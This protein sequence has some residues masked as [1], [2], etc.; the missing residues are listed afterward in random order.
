MF[1]ISH[2]PA[3]QDGDQMANSMVSPMLA[4]MGVPSHTPHSAPTDYQPHYNQHDLPP[5]TFNNLPH[6]SSSEHHSINSASTLE[7]SPKNSLNTIELDMEMP[8]QQ[9]SNIHGSVEGE[10]NSALF[11][12]HYKQIEESYR[13]T[14]QPISMQQSVRSI[15]MTQS[16]LNQFAN[17]QRAGLTNSQLHS[18]DG[19]STL[20]ASS[21]R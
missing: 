9:M 1:N 12:E 18:M 8:P 3:K 20:D 14:R 16:G 15:E 7:N 21:M 2:I 19:M 4:S 17:L 11:D 6:A 13:E 5:A 10:R